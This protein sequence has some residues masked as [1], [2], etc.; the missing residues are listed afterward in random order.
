MSAEERLFVMYES[1]RT[2][3]PGETL[4]VAFDPLGS[5]WR[6]TIYRH[7]YEGRNDEEHVLSGSGAGPNLLA[8][9][10]AL[11]EVDSPRPGPA[12]ER[13]DLT[14]DEHAAA[15]RLIQSAL[16][17]PPDAAPPSPNEARR[18]SDGT[19]AARRSLA[20]TCSICAARRMARTRWRC[21]GRC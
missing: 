2:G 11:I 5:G 1:E 13:R 21:C 3:H 14:A 20:R 10:R 17:P 19:F 9:M 7:G 4:E 12:N 16:A 8:F 6:A 18:I 15:V